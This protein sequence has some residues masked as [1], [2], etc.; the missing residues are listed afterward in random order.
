LSGCRRSRSIFP[1]N[2]IRKKYDPI[3]HHIGAPGNLQQAHIR[4]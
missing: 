3:C 4:V 1:H 2:T